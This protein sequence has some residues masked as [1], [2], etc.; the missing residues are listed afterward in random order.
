MSDTIL[1]AIIGALAGLIPPLL[2]V[3]YGWNEKR[4]IFAAKKRAIELAQNRVAFL[5]TWVQTKQSISTEKE[6]QETKELIGRELSLLFSN[7]SNTLTELESPVIT[8]KRNW[9]QKIFLIYRPHQPSAW[10]LHVLFYMFLGLISFVLVALLVSGEHFR[11][12]DPDT[13]KY[14]LPFHFGEILGG[15]FFLLLPWASFWWI[16]R[17][18]DK[19]QLERIAEHSQETNELA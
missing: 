16:A 1:V 7:L 13:G 12:I 4:G 5:N 17:R 18:I 2:T 6:F 8:L 19:K 3:L 15:S 11:G 9:F 10:V 14:D